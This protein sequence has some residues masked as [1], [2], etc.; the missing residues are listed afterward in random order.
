[1][2]F[3]RSGLGHVSHVSATARSQALRREYE[4]ARARTFSPST[5]EARSLERALSIVAAVAIGGFV[6]VLLAVAAGA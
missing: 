3:P 2:Y 6:I 4:E 1:M 5:D